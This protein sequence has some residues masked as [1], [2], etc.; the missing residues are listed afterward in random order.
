MPPNPARTRPETDRDGARPARPRRLVTTTGRSLVYAAALLPLA[1]AALAGTLA[2]RG[3]SAA[4]RWRRL[5]GLLPTAEPVPE[6]R[7]PSAVAVA[8]H[9]VASLLLGAAALVPGGVLL[10][11]VLRGALYGL[12][13]PGP[14]DTSWGGP[15]RAGAWLAHFLVGIPFTVAALAAL[16]GV[17]AVH[18]RLTLALHGARRP[19]WL[20]PVTVLISLVA[21]L[22]VVAWTR[23]I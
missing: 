13:D 9:A 14:Y 11:M 8:A 2:G 4:A 5:R 16:V 21:V 18:Q 1:V 7:P 15:T 10:L 3:W 22:L 6:G 23:Q 17:A 20:V 19:G 12:V